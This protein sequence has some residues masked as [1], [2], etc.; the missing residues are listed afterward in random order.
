MFKIIIFYEIV[1]VVFWN[2]LYFANGD[3]NSWVGN[4][5]LTAIYTFLSTMALGLTIVYVM[6]I[7][8]KLSG[9]LD[10]IKKVKDPRRDVGNQ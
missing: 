6:Y 5:F 2:V 3:F 8:A 9:F 1:F 7:S 4:Q 10:K